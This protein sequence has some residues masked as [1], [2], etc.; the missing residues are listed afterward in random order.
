MQ[1]CIDH[2][3]I[4]EVQSIKANS[5][6]QGPPNQERRRAEP[7]LVGVVRGLAMLRWTEDDS[8]TL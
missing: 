5:R 1:K 8:G 7:D 4:K 3:V 2:D 6:A